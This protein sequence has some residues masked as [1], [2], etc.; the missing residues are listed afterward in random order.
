MLPSRLLD[1]KLDLIFKR[2]FTQAPDLLIDLINAVRINE[3]P[4]VGIEILNP[5]VT[6]EDINKKLVVL[7]ILARDATGQV[8]NVEMQTRQHMGL[9]SRMVFYLTRLLSRQLEAGEDYH[10]VKPVIGITLLDFNLFPD[11]ERAVWDFELRDPECPA[12]KLDRS[13]LLHLVEMPKAD[14]LPSKTH[15]ALADWITW[16][17]HWQEDTIMQQIHHPAVQKAHQ[18]LHALSRDEQAWIDAIQRERTL[19]LEATF[20][21]EKAEAEAKAEA[22]GLTKGLMEGR[23]SLLLHLL[24]AKFGDVPPSVEERLQQAEP[25]QLEHWGD[26]VLFAETLD[27]VFSPH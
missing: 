15:Q 26:R 13:F 18:H 22:R 19:S 24:R 11:T 9:P 14:R 17:R 25:A 12:V 3:Q 23:A 2:L 20:T 7:D 16:F 5:Q 4:V 10:Q 1:P 8:L 27:Q 6:P 21:A